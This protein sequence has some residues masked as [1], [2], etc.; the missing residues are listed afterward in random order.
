MKD[1]VSCMKT[2]WQG[3][4]PAS[5]TFI[6]T[7]KWERGT[8]IEENLTNRTWGVSCGQKFGHGHFSRRGGEIEER[9]GSEME[10][11]EPL[12]HFHIEYNLKNRTRG[13]SCGRK[14]GHGHFSRSGSEKEERETALALPHF[15]IEENLKNRTEG[16]VVTDDS[17]M[18]I[19]LG[20]EV[21][22][23]NEKPLSHFHIDE[24]LEIR[25]WGLSCGRKFG[26]DGRLSWRGSEKEERETSTSLPHRGK[27]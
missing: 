9:R 4:A 27:P 3:I 25:T 20:V 23:R 24:N 19:F 10:E 2:I 21:R 18:G 13:V 5:W 14:L 12:P 11:W 22:K 8:N 1:G 6:L 17:V 15:H 7:W 26:H 16:R